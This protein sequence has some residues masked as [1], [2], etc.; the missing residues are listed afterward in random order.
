MKYILILLFISSSAMAQKDTVITLPMQDG[1]VF[2]EKVYQDAGTKNDLFLKAKDVFLRLFPDTK[3]VIQNEDKDNGIVAGKGYFE[4]SVARVRC[5]IR[6]LVKDNKYKVQIF[7]FYSSNTLIRNDIEKPIETSYD[8]AKER[9]R[10]KSV[11][12]S[13]IVFNDRVHYIFDE[14][15]TEMNKKLSTD[16]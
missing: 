7:D 6:I 12:N 9:T 8:K 5:T 10:S 13:W 3:D 16:F 14:I 2:Y 11:C 4:L 15:E 1:K